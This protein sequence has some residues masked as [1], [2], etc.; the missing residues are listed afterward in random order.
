MGDHQHGADTHTDGNGNVSDND[1]SVSESE[2]P[3]WVKEKWEML[4]NRHEQEGFEK[5][6]AALASEIERYEE[7]EYRF[8]CYLDYTT[9]GMSKTNYTKEAMYREFEHTVENMI[10]ER[11]KELKTK[12]AQAVE[13]LEPFAKAFEKVSRFH[14]SK[15]DAEY[16]TFLDSNTVTPTMCIGDFRIAREAL[17][18]IKGEDE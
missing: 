15:G 3:E 18:K 16:Q 4:P 9:E 1:M 13:A 8:S 11:T 17:R 6:Y 12:L 10:E 14:D 2:M 7:M 5:C